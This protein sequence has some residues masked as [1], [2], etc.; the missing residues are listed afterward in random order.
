MAEDST[1][2]KYY[3]LRVPIPIGSKY[4]YMI[5]EL[6]GMSSYERNNFIRETL[7]EVYRT[8][9]LTEVSPKYDD[10]K[11]GAE[12]VTVKNQLDDVQAELNR[13]RKSNKQLENKNTK[14]LRELEERKQSNQEEKKEAEQKE[15]SDMPELA[16]EETL[17]DEEVLSFIK[18][19]NPD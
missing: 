17:I 16:E 18:S 2:H 10:L 3:V 4:N 19:L 6:Q 13:L 14:L 5:T 1:K 8:R 15:V 9:L 11:P 7:A 12:G